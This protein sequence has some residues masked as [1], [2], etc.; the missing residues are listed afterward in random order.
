MF[1]SKSS[2]TKAVMMSRFGAVSD[3]SRFQSETYRGEQ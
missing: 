2:L 1:F 3:A